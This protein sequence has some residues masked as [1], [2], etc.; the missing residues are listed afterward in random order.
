MIG[1]D[2]LMIDPERPLPPAGFNVPE[3]ATL[4]LFGLGLAGLGAMRRKKLLSRHL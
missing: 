2:N 4:A 1:I 3:P